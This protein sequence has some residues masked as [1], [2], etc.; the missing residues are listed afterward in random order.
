MP[1]QKQDQGEI[2]TS[3]KFTREIVHEVLE[4]VLSEVWPLARPPRRFFSF[5]FFLIVWPLVRPPR[6]YP[7]IQ[8]SI[9]RLS[10]PRYA[11]SSVW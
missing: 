8:L 7:A 10:H 2:L 1:P 5:F 6:R 11:L 9:P 3:W 4:L